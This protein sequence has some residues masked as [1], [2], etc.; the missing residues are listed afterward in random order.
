VKAFGQETAM[1][2]LVVEKG[3]SGVLIDEVEQYA[4]EFATE[5]DVVE[6]ANHNSVISVAILLTIVLSSRY[7]GHE[8]R[9]GEMY[10]SPT[11]IFWT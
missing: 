2:A 3:R 5:H 10:G 6:V 8:R 1:Y 4:K 11:Y 9:V 7:I